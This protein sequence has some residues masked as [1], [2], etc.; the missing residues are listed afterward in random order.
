MLF[1]ARWFCLRD[2]RQ[3]AAFIYQDVDLL[4]RRYHWSEAEILAL[5]RARRAAY[6]DLARQSGVA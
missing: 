2:L 1:D 6:V 3:K 4:A 5:P